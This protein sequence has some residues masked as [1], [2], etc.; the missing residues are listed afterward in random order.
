M[1]L[2]GRGAMGL[3]DTNEIKKKGKAWFLNVISARGC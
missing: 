1:G 2:V 3:G